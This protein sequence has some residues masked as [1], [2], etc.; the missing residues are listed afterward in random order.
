[1]IVNKLKDDMKNTKKTDCVGYL[2]EEHG[3]NRQG[4]Q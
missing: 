2:R 1:M 3:Q 4:Y